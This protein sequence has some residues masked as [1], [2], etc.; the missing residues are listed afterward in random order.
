[1]S[2]FFLLLLLAPPLGASPNDDQKHPEEIAL[3]RQLYEEARSGNGGEILAP[4]RPASMK[5]RAPSAS[6][7]TRSGKARTP[8]PT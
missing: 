1:M 7:P 8:S 2:R 3:V 6:T 5:A 4:P